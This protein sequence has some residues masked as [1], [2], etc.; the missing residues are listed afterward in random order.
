MELL[1]DTA[2]IRVDV[3][4][5]CLV[6]VSANHRSPESLRPNVSLMLDKDP[7]PRKSRKE[8]VGNRLTHPLASV[9][10]KDEKLGEPCFAVRITLKRRHQGESC[11]LSIDPHQKRIAMIVGPVVIE[12]SVVVQAMIAE[13]STVELTEVIPIE[14]KHIADD[15]LVLDGDRSYINVHLDHLLDLA[16]HLDGAIPQRDPNP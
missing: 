13:V 6:S 7:R 8:V 1:D 10:A 14:F 15:R 2:G 16:S 9:F 5:E 4:G 12:P 11:Q 3:F